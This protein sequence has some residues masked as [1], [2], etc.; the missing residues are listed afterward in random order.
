MAMQ[1]ETADELPEIAKP[2]QPHEA[3][4]ERKRLERY[5]LWHRRFAHL[6]PDIISQLHKVTTLT[7]PVQTVNQK[8]KCEVYQIAKIRNRRNHDTQ[9]RAQYLL[10]RVF[11]DIYGPLPRSL[12]GNRYFALIINNQSRKS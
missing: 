6:G 9:P 2:D 12:T 8:E 3:Q 11:I 4:S 7:D 5:T 10:N 1:S